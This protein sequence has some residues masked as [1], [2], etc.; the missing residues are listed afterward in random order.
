MVE[1]QIDPTYKKVSI[2]IPI[3]LDEK[4]RELERT[5]K[6]KKV[7]YNEIIRTFLQYG[8]ELYVAENENRE[9][10]TNEIVF[11]Q[12]CSE[13][14]KKYR[15]FSHR[16]EVYKFCTKCVDSDKHIEKLRKIEDNYR[17]KQIYAGS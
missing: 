7:T 9:Y 10:T 12:C 14:T 4:I 2:R 13:L 3:K 17:L 16:E 15:K 8:Y 6:D 1:F 5:I 11:C